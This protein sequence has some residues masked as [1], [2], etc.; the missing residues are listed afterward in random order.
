[1]SF[2]VR[3]VPLLLLAL[4]SVTIPLRA[5]APAKSTPKFPRGSVSGRITIKDKPVPGVVVGLRKT[6]TGEDNPEP[7]LKAVTDHD[8]FYR[9]TNVAPGTYDV[10]PSAPA[11]V[12]SNSNNQ[13]GKNVIV[14]D[15]ENVEDINFSL[16]RGGVIT[17]KVTDADGRLMIQQGVYLYRVEPTAQQPQRPMVM[18][19]SMQTDDRGVY[20]FFGLTA[21]RYKVA[22][23]RPEENYSGYRSMGVLY[24]QVFHPDVTE[25]DKANIIEVR[26]GSETNDVDIKLGRPMQ[27]FTATGRVIGEDGQPAPNI[28][29]GLQRIAGQKFEYV[30]SSA[31]SDSQGNFKVEGLGPGKYGVFLPPEPSRVLRAESTTFDIIDGDVTGIT[32]RL[33]KG[34]SISGVIVLEHQDKNAWTRLLEMR[35][36][37]YIPSASGAMIFGSAGASSTLSPDGSF[38]L[39]G[40]PPGPVNLVLTS[41]RAGPPPKGFMISRIEHN[42]VVAANGIEIKDGEQLTGLRVVVSY[43]TGTV[44]GVVTYNSGSL[45]EGARIFARLI[46]PGTPAGNIANTFVDARGHFLMEGLPAGVYEVSVT[47]FLPG[48]TLRP[49]DAKQQITVQDGAVSEVSLALTLTQPQKP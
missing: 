8:G 19:R 14:G 10:V 28:H 30:Q 27:T 47:M 40:L 49:P 39:M 17:G 24:K 7:F 42:G 38:K 20:R 36:H 15:D 11:F 21:G 16:V 46:K 37:G 1:M 48:S 31:K 2:S 13:R 33:T 3:V 18:A 44:R 26:E 29:L 12:V 22:S 45:P 5:Q 41:A 23:G 6:L 32:V 43:G 25:Q 9:I 4:L 35:L 34:S